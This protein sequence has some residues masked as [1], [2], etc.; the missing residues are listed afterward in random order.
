MDDLK[1]QI[2]QTYDEIAEDFDPT[3]PHPWPETIEFVKS[4]VKGHRVIDLGCGTGRNSVYLAGQDLQVVGIDFSSSM[5]NI[6]YK[7]GRAMNTGSS[8]TFIQADIM[9]LP[10]RVSTFDAAIFIAALHHIPNEMYRLAALGEL[11][12]CLKPRAKVL[13]SVWAFDQPRFR[14]VMEEQIE[15]GDKKFVPR[16]RAEKEPR[17]VPDGNPGDVYVPWIRKDGKVF[18]RFYHLF[19]KNELEELLRNSQFD[20]GEVYR[21]KDNYY[22][23]LTK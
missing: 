19:M 12:R 6:A 4:L 23:K 2:M 10:F 8:P 21:V 11:Y 7:K 14:E 9:E 18:K 22:A 1:K 3:R 17:S 20:V 15:I 16:K 5:L 13:V